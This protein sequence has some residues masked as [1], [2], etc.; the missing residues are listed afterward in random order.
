[1]SDPCCH[2]VLNP[3]ECSLIPGFVSSCVVDCRDRVRC[4]DEINR[5]IRT[6][7]LVMY[8]LGGWTPSFINGQSQESTSDC[9]LSSLLIRRIDA[10]ARCS[11]TSH[12]T[13]GGLRFQ[14]DWCKARWVRRV[15]CSFAKT[16]TVDSSGTCSYVLAANCSSR[17]RMCDMARNFSSSSWY[18]HILLL[19]LHSSTFLSARC[20]SILVR[21]GVVQCMLL[22]G[23]S[24]VKDVWLGGRSGGM[25]G[26]LSRSGGCSGG[27]ISLSGVQ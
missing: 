9:F 17:A 20:W 1:M 27:T 5:C 15:L 7:I 16:L 4:I 24:I 22:L 6:W 25:S 21:H 2:F 8:T 26:G 11:W 23:L 13:V 12:C 18:R 3:C 10:S 14:N 19:L